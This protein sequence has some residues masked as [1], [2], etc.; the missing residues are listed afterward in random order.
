[1]V[2]A[3]AILV[4]LFSVDLPSWNPSDQLLFAGPYSFRDSI[5]RLADFG[6]VIAFLGW[7]FLLIPDQDETRQTRLAFGVAGL[8]LLFVFLTLELNSFLDD[9]VPGLRSGGISILWAVFA[10][11]LLLR[12]I[13]KRIRPL[14]YA[15]LS[16]FLLVS[17]KVFFGDLV[18]LDQFY[19]IIAFI[20]LGIV[21]LGAS[22]LYL[23]YREYFEVSPDTGDLSDQQDEQPNTN[24]TDAG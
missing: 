15:G 24:E 16:L 14:R 2:F 17:L 7:A 19:R 1:V 5:F 10:F 4:K 9:F 23:K 6:T 3:A 13:L 20:V 8:V 12:G 21:V 22:V 18:K 11:G